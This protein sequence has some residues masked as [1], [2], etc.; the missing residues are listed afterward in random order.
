MSPKPNL[1]AV[2]DLL[3]RDLAIVN[4]AIEA[5]HMERATA[6]ARAARL[7]AITAMVADRE[8][9]AADRLA[10][11]L[12]GA[13]REMDETESESGGSGTTP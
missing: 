3:K 11:L 1:R 6:D 5:I 9:T 4:A 12:K 13:Q 10:A 7:A 8:A 2:L